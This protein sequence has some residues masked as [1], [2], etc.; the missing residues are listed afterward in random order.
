[1]SYLRHS[2]RMFFHTIHIFWRGFFRFFGRLFFV[3][4]WRNPMARPVLIY[5]VFMVALGTFLFHWLE[6]WSYLDSLYFIV[7]TVTTIGFGDLSPTTPLSKLLTIFFGI[8]GIVLLLVFF[9]LIRQVRGLEI[10]NAAEKMAHS[11]Y[12]QLQ[13]LG[14]GAQEALARPVAKPPAWLELSQRFPLLHLMKGTLSRLFLLDLLR[15]T[16]SRGVL[17]YAGATVAIGAVAF[18]QVEG[19]SFLNSVYFMVVTMTTIGYGDITPT[20]PW[21]KILTIFFGLNGI[22]VLLALYDRIRAV[23]GQ[24]QLIK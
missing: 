14:E 3:D 11:D 2:I 20:L 10:V 18:H 21:G 15:D 5:A 4:L 12:P 9:D 1:M 13:K 7:I 8:N 16:H 6:H 17:V 23:R 24:D 19:W 22:V